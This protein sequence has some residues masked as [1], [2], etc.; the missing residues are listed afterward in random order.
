MMNK[1]EILSI[2]MSEAR[3]TRQMDEL[4]AS[5]YTV[6]INRRSSVREL[7]R[8]AYRLRLAGKHRM[9]EA[10]ELKILSLLEKKIT[11]RLCQKATMSS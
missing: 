9:S 1:L 8:I 3:Q 10:I 4:V 5:A 7:E 6:L 11:R 2:R